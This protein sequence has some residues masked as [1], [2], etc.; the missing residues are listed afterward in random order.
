[1]FMLKYK[2]KVDTSDGYFEIT[3]DGRIVM[4]VGSRPTPAELKSA[5]RELKTLH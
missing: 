2:I 3:K 1:M 5:K 4:L